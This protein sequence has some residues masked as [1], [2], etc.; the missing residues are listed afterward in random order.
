MLKKSILIVLLLLSAVVAVSGC[1]N[2]TAPNGTFGQR[3]LS[4]DQISL[5]NNTTAGVDN[6][7]GDQYYYV[8]GY[9]INN[10]P[11]DAFNVK[12]NAT[13]YDAEGNIVSTNNS[14]Y[15]NPP[16]ISADDLSFFYVEFLDNDNKI[17]RAEVKVVDANFNTL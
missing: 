10:N 13:A 6:F 9:L 16:N 17:A 14:A 8:K 1:T 4:I 3:N 11:Y 7:Y 2:K 5:S 15:I 12:V